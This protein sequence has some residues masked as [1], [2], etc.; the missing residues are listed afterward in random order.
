MLHNVQNEGRGGGGGN[1]FLNNVKKTLDL[2]RDGDGTS[3]QV[4]K[5]EKQ[6]GNN[7]QKKDMYYVLR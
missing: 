7:S 1:G 6:T 5:Q 2:V 3:K 4:G